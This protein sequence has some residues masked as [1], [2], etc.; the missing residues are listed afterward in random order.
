MA[1]LNS[2]DI[3][4][5]TLVPPLST[6]SFLVSGHQKVSHINTP[7]CSNATH[8]IV[9]LHQFFDINPCSLYKLQTVSTHVS[10]QSVCT[11]L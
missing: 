3:A 11:E 9:T 6:G 7:V 8:F 1:E 5:L 2:R 4:Q 10:T